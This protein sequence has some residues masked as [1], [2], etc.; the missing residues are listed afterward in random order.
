MRNY[1]KTPAF[2]AV[3][4]RVAIICVH[5]RHAGDLIKLGKNFHILSFLKLGHQLLVNKISST[6]LQ[7]LDDD[8]LII[9][10]FCLQHIHSLITL[11]LFIYVCRYILLISIDSLQCKY[12]ITCVGIVIVSHGYSWSFDGFEKLDF[13]DYF[14]HNLSDMINHYHHD[15]L[16]HYIS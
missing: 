1:C 9:M 8:K 7:K 10:W 5:T 11:W 6:M 13:M 4:S 3:E 16:L 15:H 2:G 12:C 14:Q